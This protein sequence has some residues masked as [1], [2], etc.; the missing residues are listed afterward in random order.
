MKETSAEVGDFKI[1]GRIINKVR[2]ADDKAI[3]A[4]IQEEL[5]DMVNRLV[6]TGRKYGMEINIDKVGHFKWPGSVLT[7]DG[8]WTREIKMRLDV[9]K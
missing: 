2:F 5:Q 7:R 4:K 9:A 3:I 8:Y 6:D 1:G